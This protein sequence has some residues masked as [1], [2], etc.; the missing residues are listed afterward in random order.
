MIVLNGAYSQGVRCPYTGGAE[1][2]ILVAFTSD[3]SCSVK[4]PPV[5]NAIQ[6]H[7]CPCTRHESCSRYICLWCLFNGLVSRPTD[8]LCQFSTVI[9]NAWCLYA[10][11]LWMISPDTVSAASS[12]AF[13]PRKNTLSC[14]AYIITSQQ[15]PSWACVPKFVHMPNAGAAQTQSFAA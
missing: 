15:G 10:C 2:D 6:M 3:S 7:A 4:N 9:Y 5:P 12:I 1:W 8:R 14:C 13:Y 11:S